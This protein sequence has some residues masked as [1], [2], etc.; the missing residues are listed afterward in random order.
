MFGTL[1]ESIRTVVEGEG[2]VDKVDRFER[3]NARY[4]KRGSKRGSFKS[5]KQATNRMSRRE[6]NRKISQGRPDDIRKSVI[7]GYAS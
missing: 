5:L 1:I 4:G 2:H 3:M 7:K 6:A